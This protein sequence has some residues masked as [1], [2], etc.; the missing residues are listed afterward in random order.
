M[1]FGRIRANQSRSSI[2]ISLN[3]EWAE[4][5]DGCPSSRATQVRH[6]P[7]FSGWPQGGC[8]LLSVCAWDGELRCVGVVVGR[9]AAGELTDAEREGG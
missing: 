3:L 8:P 1:D 7:P 9:E 5:G 2:T 4:S 6:P